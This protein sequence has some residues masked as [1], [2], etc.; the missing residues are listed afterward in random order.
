MRRQLRA[1]L[2]LHGYTSPNVPSRETLAR[3]LRSAGVD[4]ELHTPLAPEGE[5]RRDPFNPSGESSWF[6]YATDRSNLVPQGID[7]ANLADVHHVMYSPWESHGSVELA[8]WDQLC[9]LAEHGADHVALVGESQGGV[10]AALLGIEW[11]RQ[12]PQ[13]QLGWIGLVRTAPDPH[14]WQP[15]PMNDSA[16]FTFNDE[17]AQVPPRYATQFCVVL[18]ADDET[19]RTY[20]S[21]AALGPL[22]INNQ[23][24]NSGIGIHQ[25][26]EGNVN[27]RILP[28]VTHD[29][30]E[31]DVFSA[32]AAALAGG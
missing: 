21:L 32:L 27:L 17:W 19:Y 10:M 13:N 26:A 5:H 14:T 18:G 20:T 28:G 6:R 7:Y 16:T 11:N 12:H 30:H 25:S 4:A 9:V 1:L 22:L 24:S 8:L 15:R 3:A 31:D 2:F 29:S 23:I